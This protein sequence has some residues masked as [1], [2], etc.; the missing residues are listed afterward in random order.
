M[1]RSQVQQPSMTPF[2]F[3]HT[4]RMIRVWLEDRRKHRKSS[5]TTTNNYYLQQITTCP[6]WQ[7]LHNSFLPMKPTLVLRHCH[8]TLPQ[9]ATTAAVVAHNIVTNIHSDH[10]H[11]NGAQ[12]TTA[13]NKYYSSACMRCAGS[14]LL[15]YLYL[16]TWAWACRLRSFDIKFCKMYMPHFTSCVGV[17]RH[18]EI[19]N[20]NIATSRGMLH[21]SVLYSVS[22]MRSIC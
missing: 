4:S 8:H 13:P 9:C 7:T 5:V 16:T 3:W 12:H 22:D 6:S 17:T 14:P 19:R 21:C 20:T 1:P 10:T 18:V 11:N 15:Q 2:F